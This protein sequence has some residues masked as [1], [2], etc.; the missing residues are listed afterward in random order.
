MTA[1]NR[2]LQF[3][4]LR[5]LGKLLQGMGLFLNLTTTLMCALY[6]KLYLIIKIAFTD[7]LLLCCYIIYIVSVPRKDVHTG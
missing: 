3:T 2:K 5:S 7:F 4:N 1:G 6:G